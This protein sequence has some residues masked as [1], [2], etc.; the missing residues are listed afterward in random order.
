VTPFGGSSVFVEFLKRIGFAERIRRE[1]PVG[2]KSNNA[3]P[4]GEIFTAFL[5]AVVARLTRGLKQEAARVQQWRAMDAVYAVGE[6]QL[7]LLGWDC[8]RRFVVIGEEIREKKSSLG[9]KVFEVPGYTFRIFVS[10]RAEAPEGVWRDDN[11]RACVEQRIEELKSDLAADNFC[12]QEFFA[13]EAAFLGILMLF[14][15]LAEFQLAGASFPLR[16][17]PGACGSSN[18]APFIGGLEKRN[19]LFDNLWAYPVPTSRKL[20]LQP[21]T[22]A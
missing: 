16:S 21:E 7:P 18:G 11:P 17:H 3:I 12:R 15:L 1:V 19:S 22:E 10:N 9:R 5:V 2:L 6:F 14:N 13:T 8:A 4:A 20:E